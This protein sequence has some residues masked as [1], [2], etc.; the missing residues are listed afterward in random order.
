MAKVWKLLALLLVITALVW[1]AT[2]WRWQSAHVDPG[3]RDIVVTL[4]VLPIAL[5]LMLAGVIWSIGRLRTYAVAPATPATVAPPQASTP[6]LA[7]RPQAPRF[8]VL[9]SAV[10][11]RTDREWSNAQ[12]SIAKGE[13]RP[14]LDEQLKDDDG[15]AV[16]T[17]PVPDLSTHA[18]R[19]AMDELQARLAQDRPEIWA[20]HESAPEVLRAL[21]SLEMAASSMRDALEA[22][23]PALSAPLPSS[24]SKPSAP[25]LPPTV[26]I[27]VAI[28][29]RWPAQT[30]QLASAWIEQLL[31]PFIDS[32]LKAA[33]Q[34][35]AMA[36]SMRLAVQLHLHPVDDA[37][38]FWAVL[39][40][41]LMQWQRDQEAGLL[42]AMAADSL[43]GENDA[44]A[45]AAAQELF[46][47]S[48][49][50]G[51]VPG[52]GAAG[53]LLSSSAWPALP[54]AEAPQAQL[55]RANLLRR[56]K[57]ADASG[58]VSPQTL[59]Q[60]AEDALRA[61]GWQAVQVQHIT[62]DTDHRASRTGEV[63]ETLQTLLPHLDPGE[64]ALRLGVGCG[65]LG[66]ARL[67]ACL[68]LTAGQVS[69]S[70]QPALVLGAFPAFERF[71]A[72]LTPATAPPEPA[73][74]QAA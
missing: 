52:E 5:T 12:S 14:E 53:L 37:E 1:L 3:T 31:D 46:S 10:H 69:R 26:S 57:S 73:A 54:D 60:S 47:G 64:H 41:Q 66:V 72:L 42:W 62:S 23:W 16:F 13:C 19:D 24:R 30:Q 51:R 25:T 58:R 9:S 39:D 65:D 70:Q 36:H 33:G 38:A 35:R 18:L 48:N 74:A 28:P 67:L 40:Q 6:A 43:V 21:A 71:A 11:L 7:E 49:Q 61:S 2:M 55:H 56:D 59:L 45:M 29:A 44:A 22:Q 63:F 34:S 32:G 4:V 8:R 50:R 68:A 20:N 27:R 17:A 15:I